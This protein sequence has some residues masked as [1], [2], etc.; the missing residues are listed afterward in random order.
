MSAISLPIVEL[1]ANCSGPSATADVRLTIASHPVHLRLTVPT[2]PT[3]VRDM[4]PLFHG[5]TN[6]VVDIAEKNVEQQGEHVSCR[7]GCGACCRQIVPISESE[8]HAVRKLVD[9]MTEPRRTQVKERFAAGVKRMAEAGMLKRLRTIERERD[10]TE[11]GL[12]YFRVGVPCPFLEEESCS[13]HKD[14][15]LACREY[16]VTS[17][18]E[19]CAQQEPGKVRGVPIPADVSHAVRAADRGSSSVGWVPLLLAL[20]WAESHPEPPVTQTGPAI[21]QEVFGKLTGRTP[22]AP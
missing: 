3:P 6:L 7:A 9:D 12:T 20:D 8:A 11:L 21:V 15:P 5:L 19:Y 10:A 13:I 2:G 1:R 16:L 17:P 18:P 4:L 14:R 22:P